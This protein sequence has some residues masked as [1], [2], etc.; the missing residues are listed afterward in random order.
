M[1]DFEDLSLWFSLL[2]IVVGID[3]WLL[4]HIVH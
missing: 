1:L 4:F 3:L 2:Q